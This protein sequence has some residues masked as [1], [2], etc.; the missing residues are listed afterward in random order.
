MRS[1]NLRP[2]KDAHLYSSMGHERETTQRKHKASL[3]WETLR[4]KNLDREIMLKYLEKHVRRT[5]GYL[6]AK[7]ILI[8][9]NRAQRRALY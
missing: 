9:R 2:G 6:D 4:K 5:F 1:S 8:I 3:F 7:K